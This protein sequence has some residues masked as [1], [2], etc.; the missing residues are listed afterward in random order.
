MDRELELVV[1]PHLITELASVLGRPRFRRYLTEAE[2]RSYVSE[3]ARHS[4]RLPDPASP[5]SRSRDPKDDYLLALAGTEGVVALVSGDRDL[6]DMT[7]DDPP[8][9][10]PAQAVEQLL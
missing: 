8:V 5:P 10:T 9:L 6:T 7:D 2:V 3:V 4:R 1:C